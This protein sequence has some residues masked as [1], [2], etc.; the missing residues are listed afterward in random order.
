MAWKTATYALEDLCLHSEYVQPLQDE[1]RDLLHTGINDSVEGLPLL[2]S[3]VKESVRTTNTDASMRHHEIKLAI[4]TENR[5]SNRPA[6]S[7]GDIRLQRWLDSFD[8]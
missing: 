1:I 6:Q 8:G 3:F 5:T 4:S 2:D 7:L